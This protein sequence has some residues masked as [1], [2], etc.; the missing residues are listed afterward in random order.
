MTP[1]ADNPDPDLEVLKPFLNLR[2]VITATWYFI[3]FILLLL[4]FLV[5]YRKQN[6]DK[7][8]IWKFSEFSLRESNLS[9]LNR[10]KATLSSPNN[11]FEFRA[12][13]SRSVA[14]I[15]NT[16]EKSTVSVCLMWENDENNRIFSQ[17]FKST[18]NKKETKLWKEADECSSLFPLRKWNTVEFQEHLPFF[19]TFFSQKPKKRLFQSLFWKKKKQCFVLLSLIELLITENWMAKLI[20]D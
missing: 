19:L 16:K 15:S 4:I 2:K 8:K 3:S 18:K 12:R 10:S 6:R 13:N 17:F 1:D 5:R 9:T 11:K 14:E 20:I 7:K